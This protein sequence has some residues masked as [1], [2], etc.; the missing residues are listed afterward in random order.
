MFINTQ[1]DSRGDK[2]LVKLDV[3]GGMT[4]DVRGHNISAGTIALANDN[5]DD[6][7]NARYDDICAALEAG[8][9]IVYDCNKE[10]GYWKP[11]TP[12]R[13]PAKKAPPKKE[14]P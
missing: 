14:A 2:S 3:V 12:K 4:L 13:A 1:V 5:D 9:V 8:D 10:V 7:L 6:A 11:A